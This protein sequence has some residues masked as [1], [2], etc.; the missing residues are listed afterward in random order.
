M[1]DSFRL[2]CGT[3]TIKKK[4][5]IMNKKCYIGVI[6]ALMVIILLQ[7]NNIIINAIGL[8]LFCLSIIINS[9]IIYEEFNKSKKNG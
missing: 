2:Y 5:E 7:V 8:V 1:N 4:V 3:F 6:S 9:V